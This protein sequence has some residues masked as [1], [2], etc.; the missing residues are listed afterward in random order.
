MIKTVLVIGA[1]RGIG[2]AVAE[3]FHNT[4]NRVL[5]VS[6]SPAVAGEWIQADIGTSDGLQHLLK[7]I[8]QTPIDALLFMGGIWEKNAFMESFDFQKST[9]TETRRIISVN[10][11]AP[12]E[13]TKGLSNN[14]SSASNPRAIYMGS[15]S[16]I[17]QRAS[18]EVAYTAS[19]FGLRGVTQALRL[20]L[21]NQN[22]GFTVINPG[23][24][25]TEEVLED[26]EEGRFHKQTPIPLQDLI[27]TI[28]W[29]LTLSSSVE[30]GDINLSQKKADNEH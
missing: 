12:I 21:K 10:L 23:N 19:K 7:E 9:E 5:G 8:G 15:L 6:R 13:I 29:I 4:G 14:L 2:A 17:D 25:A 26:I 22:I 27:S 3:H 24:V 1:S 16:G 28:E 30:V 18:P 11:I 20:T